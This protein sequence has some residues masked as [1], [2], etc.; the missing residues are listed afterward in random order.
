MLRRT[1][2]GLEICQQG[3]RAVAI[4]WS[5]KQISLVGGKAATLEEPVLKPG[6][7]NGSISHPDRFLRAVK[8]LLTPLQ[9]RD[10]RLAVVLPDQVGQILLMNIE[11]PFKDRSEGAEIIR[12]RLKNLFP[13]KAQQ[14]TIDFQVL[15]EKESG[16]KRILVAAISKDVLQHYEALIEKA[17]FAT[18]VVDFHS[19]ALYNAYRSKIDLGRDFIFVGVD[20]QQL[21]TLVFNN[22]IPRFYRGRQI[23]K[24]PQ[25]VFRE[26]NRSLASCR[27]DFS[28]LDRIPVYLHSDWHEEELITAV[29]SI[30]EQEVQL[31]ASPLSKLMNGQPPDVLEAESN[32]LAAA[33][34]IAER[35]IQGM[36]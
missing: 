10:N 29:N 25:Q 16:Q 35:M 9:K 11:T 27:N 32:S 33:L 14:L 17:G 26:L 20:G 3:L 28:S 15:E 8:E 2:L 36:T 23:D 7:G 31:L 4:Q 34:G 30:F 6:F 12:W 24:Y 13:A 18:T 19:L 1:Y 22:Q 5:K 21:T